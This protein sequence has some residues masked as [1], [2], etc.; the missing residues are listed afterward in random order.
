MGKT[1]DI[2]E[3][4]KK[5]GITDENLVIGLKKDE[6]GTINSIKKAYKLVGGD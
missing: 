5:L 6:K 2:K 4:A 1:D 3:M